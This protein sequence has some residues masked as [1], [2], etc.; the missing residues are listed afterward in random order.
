[1]KRIFFLLAAGQGACYAAV[2]L[3]GNLRQNI[4]C[5]ELCFFAAFVLYLV[6]L[7]VLRTAENSGMPDGEGAAGTARRGKDWKGATP[8]VAP[9]RCTRAGRRDAPKRPAFFLPTTR[10]AVRLLSAL[11]LLWLV[12]WLPL[13]GLVVPRPEPASDRQL[14]LALL[15]AGWLAG[16]GLAAVRSRA[17]AL[18]AATAGLALLGAGTVARNRVYADEVAFWEATLARSPDN[19]RAL[20]NLGF[21]LAAR[22][23]VAEAEAA[24]VRAVAAAPA[25]HVPRVNLRLLRSGEP[26]A[27]GAPRCERGT[28][29]R[30]P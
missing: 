24:L 3:T 21:A 8:R 18:A 29:G 28:A 26:L 23:R 11:A 19:P 14:Y 4:V 5:A 1:M 16:Q 25:D 15:G 13:A 20:N 12:L 6:S 10:P 30:G 9:R 17:A 2:L 27:D 7:L 22:C